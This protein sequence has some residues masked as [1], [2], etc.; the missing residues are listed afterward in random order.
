MLCGYPLIQIR[1]DIWKDFMS[2]YSLTKRY[3]V[4]TVPTICASSTHYTILELQCGMPI[5]AT[6]YDSMSF[7]QFRDNY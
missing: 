3:K 7:T 4:I 6:L 2:R 1:L 5:P